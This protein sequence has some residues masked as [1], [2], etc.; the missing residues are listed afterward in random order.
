[1]PE[2]LCPNLL[3]YY[4]PPE[5]AI[6]VLGTYKLRATNVYAMQ[7]GDEMVRAYKLMRQ[8]LK[9]HYED[10][11]GSNRFKTVSLWLMRWFDA[12][13]SPESAPQVFIRSLSAGQDAIDMWDRFAANYTGCCL[14]LSKHKVLE[15]ANRCDMRLVNCV[16]GEPE[17]R[18]LITS[19][20]GRFIQASSI[21]PDGKGKLPTNNRE[22]DQFAQFDEQI[23]LATMAFAQ[24]K[25]PS[26]LS[27]NEWRLVSRR[28]SPTDPRILDGGERYGI[29]ATYLNLN[30]I[31]ILPAFAQVTLGPK[32]DDAVSSQVTKVLERNRECSPIK[33]TLNVR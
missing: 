17:Q 31:D 12:R 28:L 26:Y 32:I 10:R 29:Q 23:D 6:K 15:I 1:M 14:S 33:S 5:T 2:I 25:A 20:H 8:V 13:F 9:E 24:L 16:Y 3:H 18:D 30:L 11:S 27:E 22:E 7:D 21:G 19:L 4:A